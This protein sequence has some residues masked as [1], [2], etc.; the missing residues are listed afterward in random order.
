MAICALGHG[1][2][3]AYLSIR[4]ALRRHLWSTV[5]GWMGR[6]GCVSVG[7]Q[8]MCLTSSCFPMSLFSVRSSPRRA[9]SATSERR[10]EGV[11]EGVG[12]LG[13]CFRRCWRQPMA[14]SR[15]TGQRP[16]RPPRRAQTRIRFEF[17]RGLG[18]LA[19]CVEA[20]PDRT[21]PTQPTASAGALLRDVEG[22]HISSLLLLIRGGFVVF[23][24]LSL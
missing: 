4:S 9:S 16:P 24:P 15:S 5:G 19:P 10:C 11:H 13:R 14:M 12:A 3:S 21:R 6:V 1:G 18:S 17:G 23:Y 7:C 22:R 2:V 20:G 8:G